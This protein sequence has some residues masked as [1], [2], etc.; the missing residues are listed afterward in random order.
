MKNSIWLLIF[1]NLLTFKTSSSFTIECNYRVVDYI[2]TVRSVYECGVKNVPILS[3]NI[4]TN[5]TGNHLNNKTN[6][7][8]TSIRIEGNSTLSFVP[9]RFSNFFPHIRAYIINSAT[10]DTLFGDEFDEFS[11]LEFL[12]FSSSKLASISSRLFEKTPN[13]IFLSLSWNQIL[14]V[15]SDL[16][17]PLDVTKIKYF[18]FYGNRCIS[19]MEQKGNTTAII[20]IINEIRV[21]CPYVNEPVITTTL[22]IPTITTTNL[23]T[24]TEDT[25][26]FPTINTEQETTTSKTTTISQETTT[27][28]N[29]TC[30]EK[31]VKELICEIKDNLK[32]LYEE[33]QEIKNE[34]LRMSANPCACK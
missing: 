32:I 12:Q 11:E 29:L 7:D 17:T 21:K 10:F 22:T 4:V 13:V 5:I 14:R 33:M 27:G 25:T 19:K 1:V 20:E 26:N 8:V 24:T 31:N 9:R 16:F 30:S 6:I 28:Q 34:I 15:G 3:E 18:A 2:D 23:L